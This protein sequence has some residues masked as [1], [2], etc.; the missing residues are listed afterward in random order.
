MTMKILKP[1]SF[2]YDSLTI[3]EKRLIFKTI[4]YKNQ[5]QFLRDT[6]KSKKELDTVVSLYNNAIVELNVANIKKKKPLSR[7]KLYRLAI[8]L[9]KKLGVDD[10]YYKKI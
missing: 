10:G 9:S 2:S 3:S 7:P 8:N 1:I 5:T 6:G 4:G